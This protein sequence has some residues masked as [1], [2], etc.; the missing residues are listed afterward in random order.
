MILSKWYDTLLIE[1]TFVLREDMITMKNISIGENYWILESGRNLRH[2]KVLKKS[3]NLCTIKFLDNGGGIRV[4]ESRLLS[5]DEAQEIL[6]K[7][8]VKKR[9]SPY[10]YPH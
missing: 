4:N 1:H 7:E 8:K 5:E 10:D 6:E 2:V 9:K 3:G